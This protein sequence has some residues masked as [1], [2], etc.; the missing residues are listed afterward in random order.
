MGGFPDLHLQYV[1]E[2]GGE[3]LS[4]ANYPLVP[5]KANI[6]AADCS[7]GTRRQAEPRLE[8]YDFQFF[9]DEEL[10]QSWVA[11]YGP[12][13][14]FVDVTPDWQFYS[15]E[16]AVSMSVSFS[17]SY[18]SAGVLY[19]QDQCSDYLQED[20]P[21]ECSPPEGGYTCLGDCKDKLPAH[22]DRSNI[23]INIININIVMQVIQGLHLEL[24]AHH[25]C[26]G[27]RYGQCWLGLL[28][29]Q[30]VLGH[31]LG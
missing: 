18:S 23:N 7:A 4:A 8:N 12:A 14:T 9:S 10:L 16:S 15:C 13:I 3:L 1:L 17:S 5:S 31:W 28:D 6:T 20:V 26:G 2:T 21:F 25:Q 11:D 24:P 29:S 30:A 27:V 19:N 22:C